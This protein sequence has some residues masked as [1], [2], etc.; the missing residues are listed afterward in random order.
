MALSLNVALRVALRIHVA[1]TVLPPLIAS[2]G[3]EPW[4]NIQRLAVAAACITVVS[5]GDTNR[6]REP[7]RATQTY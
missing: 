2:D 1:G 7:V 4:G 6:D 5:L 3:T